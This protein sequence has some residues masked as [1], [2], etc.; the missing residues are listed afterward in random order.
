VNAWTSVPTGAKP[1]HA[2]FLYSESHQQKTRTQT[3]RTRLWAHGRQ[4]KIRDWRVRD[5]EPQKIYD[6]LQ[7]REQDERKK[8]IKFF[9]PEG[10]LDLD[11]LNQWTM[12][13]SYS[14]DSGGC[15]LVAVK[16]ENGEMNEN[17]RIVGTLGMIS[18]AKVSYQSSGSSFSTPEITAA[19]RRVCA[20]R[21]D[22]EEND[23]T[24]EVLAS[25]TCTTE[26]LES[27]IRQGEQRA[28]Q[29]GATSLIALAYAEV[30]T[31][32]NNNEYDGIKNIVK[33]TSSLFESL[34]YRISEQQ[35]P[36]VTTI[37]YEKMLSEKNLLTETNSELGSGATMNQVRKLLIP[38]SVATL[39]FIGYLVFN[40]YSNVF[41]IEQLWGSIDNGGIG[42]S[43]SSQNLQ[44]LIRDEKLGRS[45]LDDGFGS[46][47]AR[48]WEDL[49]PEE[50]REEQ[51]LMK[52]IQG[53]SIRSK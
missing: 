13:E 7:Q 44:E 27:L 28:L 34:G 24:S 29:S 37:Q 41:G 20:F 33:P 46:G 49:S 31:I 32:G 23:T 51:A 48:Q 39:F 8:A 30:D 9:D 36:G 47:R 26:I 21:M 52:V 53:Q 42:T 45:V 50:L 10:S 2:T 12:E 18:G 6:F 19:I 43:L 35:I 40:L 25:E 3:S 16:G 22:K 38:A 5:N 1:A 11:V 17:V 15:F 4:I 14:T